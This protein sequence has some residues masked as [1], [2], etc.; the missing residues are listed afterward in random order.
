[1]A[2]GRLLSFAILAAGMLGL[3]GCG[4]H[5]A[6]SVEVKGRVS[7]RGSPL[8]GGFI[9]FVP[10]EERGNSGP[11]V[12][13]TIQTD[14]TFT[15]GSG[16]PAGWYRVAVAPIPRAGLA[17][18]T[19]A[20]PYPRPPIRYRNPQLSGLHGEIKADAENIFHFQLDDA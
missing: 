7:Y 9:V 13:A 15:L 12:K 4:V 10:D 8:E 3:I 11:L 19:P 14:G 16:V 6:P 17:T 2:G 5:E 1:M 18:P 20:D